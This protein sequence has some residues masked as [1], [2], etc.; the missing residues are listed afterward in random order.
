MQAILIV[1]DDQYNR[2]FY[3]ELF[4]DAGYSV[5][6]AGN[7]TEGI[8]QMTSQEHFDLILLDI[9]M[10]VLDGIETLEELRKVKDI[11]GKHGK[12]FMLTALGQDRVIE[13]A[14]RLGADGYIVKTDVSPDQLLRR[15]KEILSEV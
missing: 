4:T 11:R 2:D 15:V 10:P 5:S 1:D 8:A 13:N 9:V 6:V 14:T 3:Q 7:G 12:I